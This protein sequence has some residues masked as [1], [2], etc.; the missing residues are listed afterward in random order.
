MPFSVI[1]HVC[2]EKLPVCSFIT[3]VMEK[4]SPPLKKQIF[5]V[6]FLDD[7]LGNYFQTTNKLN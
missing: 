3:S 5:L 7:L 2:Q 4:E 1:C 6:K